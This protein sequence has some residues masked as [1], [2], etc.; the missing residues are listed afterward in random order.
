METGCTIC[1]CT[2]SC[3][4]YFVNGKKKQSLVYKNGNIF[5]NPSSSAHANEFKQF[6]DFFILWFSRNFICVKRL[7]PIINQKKSLSRSFGHPLQC[8]K[9]IRSELIV[10]RF[11]A[12]N[13]TI[14]CVYASVKER[15]G[16]NRHELIEANFC[17]ARIRHTVH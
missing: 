6:C 11:R 16:K 1:L 15:D 10:F 7:R 3:S 5:I 13:L 2:K 14:E 9:W 17:R 12:S 4:S 8:S